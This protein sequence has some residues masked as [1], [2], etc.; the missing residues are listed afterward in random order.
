M[1][2][3]SGRSEL[4]APIGVVCVIGGVSIVAT[5]LASREPL[6]LILAAAVIAPGVWAL[7]APFNEKM[8]LP[9]RKELKAKITAEH[10]E[11]ERLNANREVALDILNLYVRSGFIGRTADGK[12]VAPFIVWVTELRQFVTAAFGAY[13]E[14]L[15]TSGDEIW[16]TDVNEVFAIVHRSLLRLADKASTLV[17]RK[18]FDPELVK[19]PE[20]LVQV[21][22]GEKPFDHFFGPPQ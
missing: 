14:S 22:Q 6:L 2:D 11:E 20:W 21:S 10:A 19:R 5:A 12:D 7:C 16:T 1:A 9:G 13:E 15:I 8:W 4:F 18:D 3:E 17:V